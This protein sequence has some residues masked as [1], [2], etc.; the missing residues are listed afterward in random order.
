MIYCNMIFNA[1]I[2][3][4]GS[5]FTWNFAAM[6]AMSFLQL[7]RIVALTLL[8]GGPGFPMFDAPIAEYVLRGEISHLLPSHFTLKKTQDLVRGVIILI[9]NRYRVS[10]KIVVCST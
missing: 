9:L 5:Q 6:G 7:G 2:F 3:F 8:Q 1:F 4:S 10:Q